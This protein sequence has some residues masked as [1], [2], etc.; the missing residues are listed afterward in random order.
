MEKVKDFIRAMQR[1][2]VVLT[3]WTLIVLMSWTGKE[4]PLFLTG[5]LTAL[6]A[7]VFGERAKH[8]NTPGGIP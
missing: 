6:T 8:N 4:I 7:F 5:F 2:Y 3:G 1:P